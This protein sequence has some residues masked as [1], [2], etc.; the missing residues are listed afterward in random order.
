MLLV[1][2]CT[3]LLQYFHAVSLRCQGVGTMKFSSIRS[4][5]LVSSLLILT[6]SLA[7]SY[8]LSNRAFS[9][10]LHESTYAELEENAEY[11]SNLTAQ[12][13][14][15]WLEGHFDAYAQSTATRITLIAKDGQV[16]FDSEYEIAELDNHL[17]RK[18]VQQALTAGSA[19]SER[20]STT[21]NL[22]VLYYARSIQDH[23]SIAVLRV[24]KTLNQLG[25]YRKTYQHMFLGNL[26]VL[27]LL[28]LCITTISIMLLT[29]PLKKIQALAKQYAQG[30]LNERLSI[31]RPR[32]MADLASS[33]QHMASLLQTNRERLET[34][35]N[36]LQTIMDNLH[37][38]IL[39]L[40]PT[41]TIEVANM[42]AAKL[43]GGD[44]TGYRLG[45]VVASSAVLA[46]C[47]ACKDEGTT[48]SLTVSQ[49]KHLYGESAVLVGRRKAKTLRFLCT[50][51]STARTTTRSLVVSIQDMTEL[52][53]LEQIRKDFVAN[54]SHELKTPITSITGFSEAL[55][56]AKTDQEYQRFAQVIHRQAGNMKRIVDDLLL[57]SSLEQANA[58]PTMAWTRIEQII[59][60][61]VQSC[62]YRF[63]EKHSTLSTQIDNP[64]GYELL[65]SG[66]LLTQALTNLVIN[67][68]TYSPERSHVLL[69]CQVDDMSATFSI[70]DEG[71][72]IPLEDQERI[73]E[74][75]YRVDTARSRSQGGTGLGLSI[76][77]HITALHHG[78]IEVHSETGKGSLFIMRLPRSGSELPRLEERS[79]SLYRK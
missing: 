44:P 55:L 38:G 75:F 40:D 25:G 39:L 78:N 13:T 8:S 31:Q 65:C 63:E 11:L 59:E 18:E 70:K 24:S 7:L 77:K 4:N 37:E 53:R 21:E 26:A 60:E 33:L 54:V 3:S 35:H 57:L 64:L 28:L 79:E 36:R 27:V 20:S 19:Y 62:N 17:W 1:Y 71:I 76:V 56:Q 48:T 10:A 5:L 69:A 66:M 61:T 72:G 12:Y 9:A 14:K 41:L 22:P 45:E 68:L 47:N 30:S 67:A 50:P 16:L 52:T 46:A 29:K 43:L 15:P 42:E 49:F 32:E 51:L 34:S 74:R 73:F 23:P 58:H 2:P 6:L